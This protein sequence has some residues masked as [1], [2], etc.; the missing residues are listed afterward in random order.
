MIC[1]GTKVFKVYHIIIYQK[2]ELY[3]RFT[4]FTVCYFCFM[5]KCVYYLMFT[6]KIRGIQYLP[7]SWIGIHLAEPFCAV[8]L[9]IL[10]VVIRRYSTPLVT[11]V[12]L[13]LTTG[14]AVKLQN[15]NI[16][17]YQNAALSCKTIKV[18]IGYNTH[19][20]GYTNAILQGS[21][22]KLFEVQPW[23][24]TYFTCAG[25]TKHK[26]YYNVEFP[27]GSVCHQSCVLDDSANFCKLLDMKMLIC[28][29]V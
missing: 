21:H 26:I 15:I 29:V 22:G 11:F 19:D 2:H 18:I 6:C 27:P 13:Y 25:W 28:R 20:T 4:M 17:K 23:Y 3:L 12:A 24:D 7:V 8:F 14:R 5:L 16:S 1:N 9:N 10:H